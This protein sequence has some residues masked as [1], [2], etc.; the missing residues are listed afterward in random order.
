MVGKTMHNQKYVYRRYYCSRAL[1]ARAKCGYYNGH[2]AEK[3]EAKILETLE[4]YADRNQALAIL[5]Q[6]AERTSDH[7]EVELREVE[8]AIR[9]CEMDFETHLKLFKAG[10]ISEAQFAAANHP[11]KQRYDN[12]LPRRNELRNAVL[13]EVKREAWHENLADMMT[14]FTEDFRSLPIAQQ[15]ARLMEIIEGIRIT[16]DKTIGIRFREL[17]LGS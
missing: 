11:V 16:N 4:G 5:S 2:S 3:L 8:A 6:L 17:P 13:Q 12:L 14:T 1:K 9:A 15:K 10:H 7:R